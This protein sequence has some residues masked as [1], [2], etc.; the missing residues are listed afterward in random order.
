VLVARGAQNTA[1]C[2]KFFT[3]GSFSLKSFSFYDFL[4][5]AANEKKGYLAV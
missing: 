2:F 4:K 1:S 5:Y 3:T